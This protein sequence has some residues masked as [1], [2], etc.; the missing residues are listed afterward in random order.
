[1]TTSILFRDRTDAGKQ[2]AQLVSLYIKK[3]ES[4]IIDVPLIVYALPRGGIPVAL[5]V[6]KELGC[7]LDIIVAKKITT[8]DRPEFAIG[9]VTSD[10][11]LIWAKPHYLHQISWR[12]LK[13]AMETAQQ[14][15]EEREKQ[16]SPYCPSINPT[17]AI[18]ILVD[19]GIATG[20]TIAVAV[21]E[22]RDKQVKEIWLCS[23]LA[24]LNL[25][26]KLESWGD[27]VFLLATPDPF[28]S[29]GRFYQEFNQVSLETTITLLQE[30]NQASRNSN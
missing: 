12:G 15:A 23:P 27:R 7:P 17:G 25:V 20:M 28:L 14:K 18:A 3:L 26:P 22:I 6:A 16:L 19:D 5:P 9:A 29:V 24:P 11:N 2:L 4:E 21:Q 1:M 8:P 10:G 30:Y 13:E